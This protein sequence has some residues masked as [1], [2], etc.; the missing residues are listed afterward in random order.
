M[1]DMY[2]LSRH[3]IKFGFEVACPNQPGQVIVVGAGIGGLGAAISILLAGHDVTVLESAS[4]IGEIGAGLQVLPNSSRVLISWGLKDRL[5]EHATTPR[6]CNMLSWKGA[7][8]ARMD[9]QAYAKAF[10]APFWDFHRANLHRCLLDRTIEL[11]ARLHVNSRVDNVESAPDGQTATAILRGGR[12]LTADLI[13]GADGISS[14]LRDVLMGRP[15]PPIPTGD[16]AYRLLINAEDMMADPELR[17]FIED[18]QVNYWMGPDAHAVNYVLRGGK[19]FN[20][21]LLVPDDI[22]AASMTIDGNVEEMQALYEGWDPRITKILKLCQ[23]VQKWKLCISPSL[24]K[25]TSG[26]FT[27]LGDACHATLPYLASGCG[28]AVEDGAALGL[29]LAKLTDKS[30]PQK[31]HAL[32]IYEECRKERTE[33]VVARGNVQQYLYHL[34]DGP[35]QIERDRRLIEFQ[36]VDEEI[37]PGLISGAYKQPGSGEDP[38][39]WRYH[40][41]GSWLL[42]H[43]VEAD[44]ERRWRESTP[45]RSMP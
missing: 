32:K 26:A 21:V 17:S 6:Y 41:V 10:G 40:G 42:S 13:V 43:D 39:P 28:M 37:L 15:D 25:W 11:G 44:V 2:A 36:K 8:L 12:R 3:G 29:C 7:R 16:L 23:S 24:E 14:G 18:P 22:P 27:L 19:L 5:V 45:P 4:E 35:E 30:T 31:L 1:G 33:K 20:M 34:H 9:F 38:F